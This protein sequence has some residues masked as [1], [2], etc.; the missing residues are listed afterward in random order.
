MVSSLNVPRAGPGH[1][2]LAYED[3]ATAGAG[4]DK[5]PVL[6]V[7]GFA[8]SRRTNWLSPGWYR[9]FAEAG[10]RVIAFDHRGHGESEASHEPADYDEGLMASD[11][12]AVLDACS[13]READVFGYSMGAMVAI[14]VLLDHPGRVRRAVLGGLGENYLKPSPLQD[15]V[16][17]ALLA[18]DPATI[19]DAGAKA[20]R[21]VAD[22]Q[23]QDRRALAACWQRPRTRAGAGDLG[24]VA[25]PVLVICGEKDV[26][27]GPP[28]PLAALMPRGSASV[29]P[30]RDHMT[31]VGDRITK[32]EVLT[33]LG[34]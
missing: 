28:Q 16:P 19:R 10:R 21:T 1:L 17:A 18:D 14:R 23:K 9:S 22:A 13:V 25:N 24:R 12:A 32:N 27:T 7:H 6:L 26:I 8:S 5:L 30:Q 3:I 20:F 29:V 11:C 2:R 31:A 34:A 15:S 4:P 33:F